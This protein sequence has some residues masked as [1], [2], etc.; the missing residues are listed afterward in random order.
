ARTPTRRRSSCES[1]LALLGGDLQRAMTSGDK[2]VLEHDVKT[3]RV[4][5]RELLEHRFVVG[6]KGHDDPRAESL[7]QV[8]SQTHL[9]ISWHMKIGDRSL[10]EFK[11]SYPDRGP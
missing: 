10:S 7:L 4:D 11:V 1:F 8:D 5:G 2:Q 3:I 6:R 9:P